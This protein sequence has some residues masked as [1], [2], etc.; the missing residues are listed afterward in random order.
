MVDDDTFHKHSWTKA[1]LKETRHQ[2]FWTDKPH[3]PRANPYL[4]GI[5]KADLVIIGAGFSGLWAALQAAEENPGRKII[6]LEA[7]VAGFGASARNGGFCDVSLTHGIINGLANWKKDFAAL[8]RMGRENIK[9]ILDTL[10][11]HQINAFTELTGFILFATEEWQ[12]E[13]LLEEHELYLEYGD[14]SVFLNQIE[15]QKLVNSP[16][17]IGGIKVEDYSMMVDP[18]ELV[19]GLKKACERLGVIIYEHSKVEEIET[20][21]KVLKIRTEA[22]VVNASKVIV[23]TNAWA[24][25]GKFMRKFIIPVHDYVLVTEPLSVAQMESIGWKGR[26][27]I[28]DSANQFHYYRLTADNRILWGGYDAKYFPNNGIGFKYEISPDSFELI[29]AHF[30]NTFPQLEGL[31][32]THKWSG[33][34]GATSKFVSAFGTKYK[35]RLSWVG[36][37]SGLGVGASRFGARVALDLVDGKK[38]ERTQLKMVRKKPMAFPPPPFR[39]PIVQFTQ[40]Q[41]ANADRNNGKRGLWLKFLDSIGVGIEI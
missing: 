29:A 31:K 28:A 36:G 33:A 34:I 10:D 14:Q 38:T 40:K 2:I 20:R 18:A 35:G 37:Y 6:V 32:F 9:G 4:R 1:S 15:A 22:G 41:I 25:P 7:H 8:H 5:E 11:R 19:W 30:F 24:E 23:A 27:G 12:L 21:R 39:N 17:Y 16:T 3:K 13:D 26:E